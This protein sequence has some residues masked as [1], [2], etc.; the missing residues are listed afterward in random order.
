MYLI[1]SK[2][3]KEHFVFTDPDGQLYHFSVEGNTIKDGTK[4]SE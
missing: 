3:A 2:V 1:A 4:V